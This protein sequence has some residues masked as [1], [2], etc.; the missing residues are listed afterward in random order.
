MSEIQERVEDYL[1]MGVGTVWV[2]DPRRRRAY[3]S[4][5]EGLMERVTETL[6]VSG[7]EIAVPVVEVFAE[8]D[9]LEQNG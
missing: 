8:L 3:V 5:R 1:L 6:V 9:D 7:T 4:V 2:I